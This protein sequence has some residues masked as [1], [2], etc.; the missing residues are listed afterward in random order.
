[1]IRA[2]WTGRG[3]RGEGGGGRGEGGGGRGQ[4]GGRAL[5]IRVSLASVTCEGYTSRMSHTLFR[6]T[7]QA[8]LRETRE[9]FQF[10]PSPG[11]E[12]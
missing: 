5:F 12:V 3:E 2:A 4:G 10:S 6:S 9:C 8:H 11:A 7:S 1:M